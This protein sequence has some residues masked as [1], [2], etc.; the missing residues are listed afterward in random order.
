MYF[1]TDLVG[2]LTSAPAAGRDDARREALGLPRSSRLTGGRSL[3][4]NPVGRVAAGLGCRTRP[5]TGAD[6]W[7]DPPPHAPLCPSPLALA[8]VALARRFPAAA[9]SAAVTAVLWPLS[10]NR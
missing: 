10:P 1:R 9:R 7:L 3:L 6:V 8:Q 5:A 4:N 2:T